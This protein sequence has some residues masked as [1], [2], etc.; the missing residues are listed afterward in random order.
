MNTFAL[1]TALSAL[2]VILSFFSG[3][4]AMIRHGQGGFLGE[5]TSI[6]WRTMFDLAVFATILAAPLAR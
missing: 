4:R 3:S 5:K 2:G 6:A 1:F